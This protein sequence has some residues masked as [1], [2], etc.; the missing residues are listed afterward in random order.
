[1]ALVVAVACAFGLLEDAPCRAWLVRRYVRQD[2]LRVVAATGAVVI[3]T[4][5]A[6]KRWV[7][8]DCVVV[9]TRRIDRQTWVICNS[10][11]SGGVKR[12]VVIGAC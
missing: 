8:L 3:D 2:P 7:G 1:M 6:Y 11:L 10:Q 4:R 12:K 9:A 5:D